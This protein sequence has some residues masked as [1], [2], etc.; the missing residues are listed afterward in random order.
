MV[1]DIEASSLKELG[2]STP[3]VRTNL[4]GNS[5]KPEYRTKCQILF[6]AIN[7]HPD[8]SYEYISL[9]LNEVNR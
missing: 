2:A 4:L 1:L 8:T 3:I 7:T 9:G 6:Y 5:Y